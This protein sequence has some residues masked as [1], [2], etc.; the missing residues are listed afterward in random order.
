[1]IWFVLALLFL[2]WN[3]LVL[4]GKVWGTDGVMVALL[5]GLATVVTLL[6]GSVASIA[7]SLRL[8]LVGWALTLLMIGQLVYLGWSTYQGL[9]G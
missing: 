8:P 6:Y 5:L 9:R 4:I 1:M 2:G 7:F 3:L